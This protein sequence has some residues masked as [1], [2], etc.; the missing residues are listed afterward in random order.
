M[1]KA[2][3][4][5]HRKKVKHVKKAQ[6]IEPEKKE[7]EKKDEKNKTPEEE[8]ELADAI[9]I[10]VEDEIEAIFQKMKKDKQKKKS[11]ASKKEEEKK[12]MKGRKFTDDGLP[13]YTE[14][15]LGMN[16]PKAGTTPLCPFDCDC[17]H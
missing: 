4:H 1:E 11:E 7:V 5:L 10:T 9:E 16:N 13:I 6:I 8:D 2:K 17:C 14:E 15:E 12:R 3:I